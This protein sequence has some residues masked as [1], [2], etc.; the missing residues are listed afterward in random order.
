LARLKELDRKCEQAR[1]EKL[2]PIRRELIGRCVREN[3]RT[4][5]D[6]EAEFGDWG[7]TRPL[8]SG[9]ARGGKFYDLPECVAAARA[10]AGYR[11]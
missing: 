10:R 11:Q 4:H 6:C 9:R 7:D 8:A 5:A 3:K 1:S 2:T